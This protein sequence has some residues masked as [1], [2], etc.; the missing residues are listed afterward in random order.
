VGGPP[1]GKVET[2]WGLPCPFYTPTNELK[3]TDNS[4]DR[5]SSNDLTAGKKVNQVFNI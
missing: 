2:S 3:Y 5:K 1:G 4:A